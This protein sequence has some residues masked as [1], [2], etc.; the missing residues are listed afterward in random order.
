M[1]I[2]L[3]NFEHLLDGANTLH[4]ILQRAPDVKLLITSRELLHLQAEWTMEIHGWPIRKLPRSRNWNPT[5]RR[6]S[7]CNVHVRPGLTSD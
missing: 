6:C 3:D 1:L 4:E 5:A 2:A 7:S